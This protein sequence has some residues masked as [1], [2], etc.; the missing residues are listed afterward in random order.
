M[1]GLSQALGAHLGQKVFTCIRQ[2]SQGPTFGIKGGAAGGGYSQ[3]VPMEDFNLHLT[4]DIHAVTRGQQPAGGG[5]R[6]AHAARARSARRRQARQSHVPRTANS[7]TAQRR[8]LAKLG[9]QAKTLADLSTEEK[10]RM[11]RLDIDPASIT[12][13]RV[14]D[15]NDRLLRKIQIGLGDEEK[16]QRAHHR[17]TTSPSPA[18]SWR[19]WRLTTGLAG[20]ARAAGPH[21]HSAPTRAGE[22]RH[23]RRPGR[24]GRVD[25]LDERRDHAEPDAD[26]GRHAGLRARRAV[27]QHRARQLVHRG[28]SD[29]A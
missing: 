25:R 15:I 26:A 6:C 28:R 17:L 11:F 22:A 4:G 1:V 24:G 10:R 14:V 13:Q 23:G 8:R 2:P 9:I 7:P 19:S 18:K 27:R 12:W 20:H 5:D 21:R 3:I 29:R 16:G